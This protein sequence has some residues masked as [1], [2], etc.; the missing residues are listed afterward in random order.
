VR[1]GKLSLRF[2][3]AATFA[4]TTLMTVAA[5]AQTETVIWDFKDPTG[6]IPY[7]GLAIDAAGNLYGTTVNGGRQTAGVVYEL[8]PAAGG[9]WTQTVLHNFGKETTKDGY[10]SYATPV[11]DAAGDFYGT[12]AFGGAHASGTVFE[13]V[14]TT[15][16]TW[17][18]KLLHSF[19]GP[20][21]KSSQASVILDPSGNIY[22]TTTYGGASYAS[23]ACAFTSSLKGCGTVFELTPNGSGGWIEHVLHSFSQNGVDGFEPSA[24]LVRDV[25][26]NLYGTTNFGGDYNYG[27]VFELSPA[28]GGAWTETIIHS[29]DNNGV[30]GT[31]PEYGGL[32][33]DAAGNLYG[34]AGGGGT[35]DQ[36]IVYELSPSTGGAW[37]ETVIYSFSDNS[38]N[39][40]GS[41]GSA[42]GALIFDAE[43][44]LYSARASGG[45][46]G[47]GMVYKLTPSTGG[48]WTQTVLYSFG[49]L[50]DGEFPFPGLV[51]DSA[52]NLYGATEYGGVGRNLFCS[53]LNCGTVFEITP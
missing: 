45:T 44:N 8:S 32:I 53:Y 34:I 7:S 26:G 37:T 17:N 21:G 18:E 51:F 41:I 31:Y 38:A 22:G 48:T 5:G 46:Y 19:K 20:D 27:T 3:V 9:G 14:P 43:G 42:G 6:I 12:T 24:P 36:G 4:V 16:G 11:F 40:P 35:G 15:G 23:G 25:A 2:I 47:Y 28:A 52:G 49:A 13:M 29:F 1:N 10:Y 39:N 50:P 30:D 33:F